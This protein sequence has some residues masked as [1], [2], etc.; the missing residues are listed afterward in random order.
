MLNQIRIRR[1]LKRKIKIKGNF[2]ILTSEREQT[3]FQLRLVSSEKITALK[4]LSIAIV[5]GV[6]KD[7]G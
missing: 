7:A 1:P 4:C 6:T 3:V 2:L 5:E